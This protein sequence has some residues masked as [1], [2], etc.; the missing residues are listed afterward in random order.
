MIVP[1]IHVVKLSQSK[2]MFNKLVK[3]KNVQKPVE[4]KWM[5]EKAY[6]NIFLRIYQ[7][8]DTKS[9]DLNRNYI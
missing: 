8:V 3:N 1:W 5:Q 6:S 7:E 4:Q 9:F 2:K